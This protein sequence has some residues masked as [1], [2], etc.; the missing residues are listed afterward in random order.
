[1]SDR[2]SF[3]VVAFDTFQSISCEWILSRCFASCIQLPKLC[4]AKQECEGKGYGAQQL[5]KV[6]SM[7]CMSASVAPMRACLC[8]CVESFFLIFCDKRAKGFL[9]SQSGPRGSGVTSASNAFEKQVCPDTDCLLFIS[10]GLFIEQFFHVAAV[11]L[12]F[13]FFRIGLGSV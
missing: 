8:V 6:I 5:L 3:A 2:H 4:Q 9:S 10:S 7:H 13:I 11:F 1:M 12:Q